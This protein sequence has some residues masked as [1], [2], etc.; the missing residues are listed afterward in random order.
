MTNRSGFTFIEVLVAMLI[1]VMAVLAAVDVVHGSVKATQQAKEITLASQL[2]QK[3]MV[4]LETKIETDGFD[5]GCEKKKEGKF[6]APNEKY[7]WTTYCTELDFN[8]SETA[9]QVTG[10]DDKEKEEAN[11]E[12]QI[13]KMILDTASKYMSQSLRE[14]HAEISWIEGKDK[15]TIDATTHFARYD[16]NLSI[17]GLPGGGGTATPAPSPTPTGG[18]H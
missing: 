16:Q 12:N 5:K 10:G 3:T 13:Q 9:K 17:G 1:F 11:S 6:E 2:L 15:H 14:L 4:D 18:A 7:S 8:L